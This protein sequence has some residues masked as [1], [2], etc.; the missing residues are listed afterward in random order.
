MNGEQYLTGWAQLSIPERQNDVS[1]V[2]WAHHTAALSYDLSSK[3]SRR[4]NRAFVREGKI[5]TRQYASASD[6]W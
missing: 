5:E 1:C 2:N 4:G 3:K 6:T